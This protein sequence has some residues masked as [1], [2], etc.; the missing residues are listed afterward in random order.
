MDQADEELRATIQHIWPFQ[1]NKILDLLIP[2]ID[3]LNRGNLTVGKIYASILL[4]EAWRS[5][6]LN[7]KTKGIPVIFR[8]ILLNRFYCDF[9][10]FFIVYV[11]FFVS[12][13]N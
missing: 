5:S 10:L 13:Y 2:R 11:F 3:Q 12:L 7:T 8:T 1:A 9:L 6:K 4:I